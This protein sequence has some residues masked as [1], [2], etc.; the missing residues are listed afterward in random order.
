[1]WRL[2]LGRGCGGT[3]LTSLLSLHGLARLDF[4]LDHLPRSGIAHDVLGLHTSII[5]HE[6]ASQANR[7]KTLFSN[8][9]SCVK[10]IRT[11]G[12]T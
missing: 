5:S 7:M 10:M 4:S 11:N 3:L 6:N 2:E 1:M 9:Y 12:P 8:N